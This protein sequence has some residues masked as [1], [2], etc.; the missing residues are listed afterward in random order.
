MGGG[1]A[2]HSVTCSR[3]SPPCPVTGPP[4]PSS[5]SWP[6]LCCWDTNDRVLIPEGL[7]IQE[8]IPPLSSPPLPSAQHCFA[9]RSSHW[10]GISGMKGCCRLDGVIHKCTG[11][12]CLHA[13]LAVF[14]SFFFFLHFSKCGQSFALFHPPRLMWQVCLTGCRVTTDH[15]R[16]CIKDGGGLIPSEHTEPQIIIF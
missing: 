12:A 14:F 2:G 16:V 4:L 11:S 7:P 9:F 15:K 3:R 10:G 6:H 13:P 5:S 8:I 1:G